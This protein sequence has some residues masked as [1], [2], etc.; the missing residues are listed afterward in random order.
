MVFLLFLNFDF[1]QTQFVVILIHTLQTGF[2]DCDFPVWGVYFLTTYMIMMLVLF[3]NFY[4]Q[5]YLKNQNLKEKKAEK[6]GL[7]SNGVSNGHSNGRSN[8]HTKLQ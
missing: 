1:F 7:V 5:S 3:G 8:G 2:T 6:D 4:L